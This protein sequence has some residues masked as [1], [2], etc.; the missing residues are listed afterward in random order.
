M[1]CE[2]CGKKL[3][4]PQALYCPYCGSKINHGD[5]EN[6]PQQPAQ[7]IPE[8]PVAPPIPEPVSVIP[9]PAPIPEPVPV[10]LPQPVQEVPAQEPQPIGG[11]PFQEP[12]TADRKSVV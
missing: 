12:V 4:R 1:N 6:K 9:E 2:I 7:S 3:I 11:F 5:D 8:A 10:E